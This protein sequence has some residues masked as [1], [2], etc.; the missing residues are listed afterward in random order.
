MFTKRLSVC[1]MVCLCAGFVG[2]AFADDLVPPRNW[3]RG[4]PGTTYQQWE[5][6]TDASQNVPPDSVDNLYGD[7]YA[8]VYYLGTVPPWAN[9]WHYN[10]EE[11]LGRGVWYPDFIELYI[12][13]TPDPNELKI[14]WLQI[15]FHVGELGSD[16]PVLTTYPS[17]TSQPEL[18]SMQS[19]DDYWWHGTY[20]IMIEPNPEAETIKIDAPECMIYI[21]EIVVDTL[22]T[23]EP[24]TALLLLP[25]AF[26]LRRRR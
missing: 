11:D 20:E 9:Q 24:G 4:D 12:P 21:D 1:V 6:Y 17:M 13:N 18:I 15:T 14:I 19:L 16:D 10:E 8:T 26:F 2:S 5:F 3:Q 7:P 23:P 25:I 22:C